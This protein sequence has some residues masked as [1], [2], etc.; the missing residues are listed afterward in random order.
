M[1]IASTLNPVLVL[2]RG[3]VRDPEDGNEYEDE[4][5]DEDEDEYEDGIAGMVYPR[6]GRSIVV[7]GA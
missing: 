3:R 6:R 5:E 1:A 4:Y 7:P 2:V